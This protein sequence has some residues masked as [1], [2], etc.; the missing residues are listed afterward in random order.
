MFLHVFALQIVFMEYGGHTDTGMQ[1]NC[2][3]VY[4][5]DSLVIDMQRVT[6]SNLGRSYFVLGLK[7][8]LSI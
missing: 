3:M 4:V 7:A 1:I 6:A 2:F 5:G 8:N